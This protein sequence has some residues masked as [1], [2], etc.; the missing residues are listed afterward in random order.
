VAAVITLRRGEKVM[1][2]S[3]LAKIKAD[4]GLSIV[5]LPVNLAYAIIW[6]ESHVLRVLN[7][8]WEAEEEL[9]DMVR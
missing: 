3:E 8:R 7:T 5:Y 6:G 9:K 4:T 1:S 2:Q